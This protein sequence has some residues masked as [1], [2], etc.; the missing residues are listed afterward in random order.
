MSKKSLSANYGVS[1]HTVTTGVLAVGPHAKAIGRGIR[2]VNQRA[3][4]AAALDHL[5]GALSAARLDQDSR[6]AVEADVRKLEGE[7]QQKKLDAD[8]MGTIL[9]R[10]ATRLR[11]VGVILAETLALR[12]PIETIAGLIGTSMSLLGL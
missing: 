5:R 9:Q 10:I 12:Q 11:S 6:R 2:I 8:A 1:A 7:A 4:L 3:E